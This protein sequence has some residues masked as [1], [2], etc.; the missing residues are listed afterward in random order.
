M[1]SGFSCVVFLVPGL[2]VVTGVPYVRRYQP[3]V[4][5]FTFDLYQQDLS[6]GCDP[7]LNERR[8]PSHPDQFLDI[9]QIFPPTQ[10]EQNLGH[11]N[12]AVKNVTLCNI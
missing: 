2:V 12:R 11:F 1:S 8:G 5:R 7:Q 9:V 10:T 3:L 6:A 4:Q